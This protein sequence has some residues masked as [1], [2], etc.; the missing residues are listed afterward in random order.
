M[1]H[2]RPVHVCNS[3]GTSHCHVGQ[4][5]WPVR[6]HNPPLH[7]LSLAEAPLSSLCSQPHRASPPRWPLPGL[8]SLRHARDTEC[9][10]L[11]ACHHPDLTSRAASSRGLSVP[12]GR[13]HP[14]ASLSLKALFCIFIFEPLGKRCVHR[15]LICVL[16]ASIQSHASLWACSSPGARSVRAGPLRALVLRGLCSQ[17]CP[18]MAEACKNSG[19]ILVTVKLPS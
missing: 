6:P 17:Q 14:C 4:N 18:D 9:H 8:S 15:L 7:P 13:V 3:P 2:P 16:P 19:K 11:V 1:I 10:R 12:R 5:P